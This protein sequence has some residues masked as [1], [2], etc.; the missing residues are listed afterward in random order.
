MNWYDERE[1]G[2]GDEFL[3]EI[4]RSI[5]LIDGNPVAWPSWPGESR[6][7][8]FVMRRFPYVIAYRARAAE[9]TILAFAHASRR[10]EY[11]RGRLDDK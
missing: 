7:R 11:W 8:R 1:P 10:P 2:L 9:V 4:D 3:L 6:A 5:A